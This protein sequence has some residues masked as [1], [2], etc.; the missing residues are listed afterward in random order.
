M[1]VQIRSGR[2]SACS[3]QF[4]SVTSPSAEGTSP[5]SAGGYVPLVKVVVLLDRLRHVPRA[6]HALPRHRCQH[7]RHKWHEPQRKRQL[8]R[9]KWHDRRHKWQHGQHNWQ[10]GQQ[11]WQHGHLREFRP[12]SSLLAHSSRQRAD[13][14]QETEDRRGERG[15][16][17]CD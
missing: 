2:A 13:L 6:A 9:Y 8:C 4:T 3:T 17:G 7:P 5:L 15:G 11:N 14:A 12:V 10:H 16:Q 1:S